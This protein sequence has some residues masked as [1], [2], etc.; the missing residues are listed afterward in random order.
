[1]HSAW[2]HAP[3]PENVASIRAY[4]LCAKYYGDNF[5]GFG[6]GTPYLILFK[7]LMLR[8]QIAR[9]SARGCSTFSRPN[10]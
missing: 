6:I 2:H 5:Q 9:T 1:M 7:D 10:S 8:C 4:G 3:Y